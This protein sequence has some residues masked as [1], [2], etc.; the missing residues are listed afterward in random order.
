MKNYIACNFAQINQKSNLYYTR[1]N[2]ILPKRAAGQSPQHSAWT[3]QLQTPKKCAAEVNYVRFDLPANEPQTS[4]VDSDV[5]ATTTND[6]F[7]NI[8]PPHESNDSGNLR[9]PVPGVL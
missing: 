2:R 4:S 6:Q 9:P 7:V 3:K 5:V 1:G 8:N